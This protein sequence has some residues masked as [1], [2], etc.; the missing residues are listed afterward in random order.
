L[1]VA[2]RIDAG[3][4]EPTRTETDDD[5][6]VA[7]VVVEASAMVIAVVPAVRPVSE[8]VALPELIAH[9]PPEAITVAVPESAYSVQ[10]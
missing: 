2:T 1:S 6:T 3:V 8:H 5:F 4:D 10:D 9:E 7:A